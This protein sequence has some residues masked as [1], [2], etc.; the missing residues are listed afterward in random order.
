MD[1][2]E[3]HYLKL[4]K[5]HD[6]ELAALEKRI[7]IGKEE[8]IKSR[9]KDFMEIHLKFKVLKEK[10]EKYQK[11]ELIMEEKRLKGFKPT[12]KYLIKMMED[13]S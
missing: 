5:K 7:N 10:Q 3:N 13:Q 1:K 9:E 6:N 8:M 2:K 11:Q 12:S 4:K